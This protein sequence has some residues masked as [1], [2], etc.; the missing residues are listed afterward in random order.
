MIIIAMKK[1]NCLQKGSALLVALIFLGVLTML[2]VSV[3]LTSTTQLKIS[4]NS[5]ETNRTFHSTNAGA[6]LLLSQTILGGE[7]GEDVLLEAKSQSGVEN[8]ASSSYLSGVFSKTYTDQ[9]YD[10]QLTVSIKQKAK[11]TT[12]PRIE[13]GSS[14]QKIA[15]DYFEISST[16]QHEINPDYKPSVK[17]GIYREMVYSNSATAKTIKIPE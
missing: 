15:C 8:S 14:A 17:I 10:R 6:N 5:E 1:Y 4:A 7:R 2:G 16:Y 12:C 13:K 9:I 11:G 3:A